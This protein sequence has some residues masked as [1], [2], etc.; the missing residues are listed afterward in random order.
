MDLTFLICFILISI[1]NNRGKRKYAGEA[2]IVEFKEKRR[3]FGLDLSST[4]EP[5]RVL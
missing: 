2:R 3:G 4:K 1:R 5:K